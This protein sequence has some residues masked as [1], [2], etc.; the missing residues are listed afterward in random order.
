MEPVFHDVNSL[1]LSKLM[2]IL[3][4]TIM[5]QYEA[6]IKVFSLWSLDNSQPSVFWHYPG[7]EHTQYSSKYIMLKHIQCMQKYTCS[8]NIIRQENANLLWHPSS[9]SYVVHCMFMLLLL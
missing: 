1:A 4:C 7:K 9:G 6:D 8:L 2:M 3:H 5:S